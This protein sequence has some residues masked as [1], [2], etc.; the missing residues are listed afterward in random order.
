MSTPDP[1]S[2]TT[3]NPFLNKHL[4]I[5]STGGPKKVFIF[6]RLREL[7]C[8]I[9]IF[10]DERNWA[11]QYS[12]DFVVV[13]RSDYQECLRVLKE[14]SKK[15]KIDGII[16]FW[17]DDVLLVSKLAADMGL[18]GLPYDKAK[19]CKNK[20]LFR[21][22]CKQYGIPTPK[23]S[24]VRSPEDLQ[25]VKDTF[26]FPVVAK[27][28]WGDSSSYVV[29]VDAIEELEPT[30]EYIRTNN[31]SEKNIYDSTI[32]LSE[33]K[34]ILIEEYIDGEEV[35][36]NGII[37]N[38]RLKIY[39]VADNDKTEE[40]FF[41]ETGFSMPS[42]LP[43]DEQK[44]LVDQIDRIFEV[45][46][47]QNA[48]FQF[49]AK[50]TDNG[51]V[52]IELNL[53]MGG[54]E[55]YFFTKNVWGVDIIENYVK[56]VMGIRIE[57]DFPDEPLTYCAGEDF[58]CEH[59]GVLVELDI[60]DKLY[61]Q[62]Y[63]D[64]FVFIKKVGDPVLVPPEGYEYLGWLSVT[65]SNMVEAKTNLRDAIDFVDFTVVRFHPTSSIGKTERK[66]P[67]SLASV[68][69]ARI[70]QSARM[71][72]VYKNIQEKDLSQLKYAIFTNTQ[73]NGVTGDYLDQKH[74]D[75]VKFFQGMLS[76][77]S[78]R[79]QVVDVTNIRKVVSHLQANDIDM[80]VNFFKDTTGNSIIEASTAG[81]LDFFQ[82][83]FV[84]ASAKCLS[85]CA[86]KIMVKKLLKYHDI[87]TPAFDYVYS[88]NDKIDP[89]LEFP[90]IVKPADTDNS[91]GISNDSVVTNA[92]Q[93]RERIQY[94][95]EELRRP[96]VIEE[97]I[98][99]YE[100]EACVIGNGNNIRVL[101]LTKISFD[102][103]PSDYW[104]ILPYEAK[105]N[106]LPEVYSKLKIERP[107]PFDATFEKLVSE[108]AIDTF[109]I[110][111]GS[112]YATVEIRVSENGNPYVIEMTPNPVLNREGSFMQ[113]AML[114][115][116]SE[117]ETIRTII[118]SAVERY[119]EGARPR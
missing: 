7:G 107:A 14:V 109:N 40:P 49:E 25:K 59:S 39:S 81:M 55:A 118:Q 38:G 76:K 12:D 28:A 30:I 66:T 56:M 97:F 3:A 15:R 105:M 98:D 86:D 96:A 18:I 5:F 102:D 29:K 37:Q 52:P 4:A 67:L 31:V 47:I 43:E 79:S 32:S 83:P 95:T 71:E 57:V 117:E 9:T 84:G 78:Y 10:N 111:N 106:L 90:M 22:M 94:I 115:E 73:A 74:R 27:P 6:Q 58:L 8:H 103:L 21:E 80:I 88:K 51:P 16:T 82:L 110:L 99:G 112:D 75:A 53:R 13:N 44:S 87:P 42:N 70:L 62:K 89:E 91:V 54:D 69:R 85:L 116:M 113:S 92:T 20:F 68:E 23:Y 63:L 26:Q 33:E 108:L 36:V 64:Q 41:I 77:L 34:Q 24:Y 65:G 50:S 11:V 60:D 72:Q 1:V 93:L 101:P 45:L 35:D 2:A 17:N 119:Q 46:G 48:C 104:H 114:S 100:V 61:K 19:L